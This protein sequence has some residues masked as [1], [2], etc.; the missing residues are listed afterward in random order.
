M[1][2]TKYQ[3]IKKYGIL[4]GLLVRRFKNMSDFVSPLIK[5]EL[6]INSIFIDRTDTSM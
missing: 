3:F 6:T 4:G 5:R 1:I 2:I